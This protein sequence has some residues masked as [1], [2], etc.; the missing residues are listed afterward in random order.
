M[1]DYGSEDREC[2][3]TLFD[4][5]CEQAVAQEASPVRFLLLKYR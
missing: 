3:D 2:Y 5:E 4:V 1:H